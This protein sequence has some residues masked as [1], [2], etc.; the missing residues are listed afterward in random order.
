MDD[1]KRIQLIEPVIGEEEI[2]AVTK[3]LR[4]GWL[5]EGSKTREFEAM[6]AEFIGAKHALATNNCTTALELSLRITGV[7]RGDKVIVPDFTHPATAD[8]VMLV[9]ATPVLVDVDF[10]TYNIDWNQFQKAITNK[11]KCVLP[12]SWGGCPL[13]PKIMDDLRKDHGL[14][15]LEDAACSLGSEFKGIKSG[16]MAD[17]SCFSFHPRKIITTGEGGMITTDNADYAERALS[18]KRFGSKLI[19]GKMKFVSMGTNF[20]LSDVLAAIGVE[21]M[22]K[23]DKILKR[24]ISLAHVYDE[25]LEDVDYLRAP[26]VEKGVKHV[27]QT[28]AV[29]VEKEGARDKIIQRLRQKGIET[30]IGTYSLHMQPGFEHLRRIG[31][32]KTSER[33]FRNLLALPMCH[34]MTREE[35]ER[36]VSEIQSVLV[37]LKP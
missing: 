15:I 12:V 5:T 1:N 31:K 23:I 10:Y 22:K 8:V 35:Q 26:H 3:V 27:Y 16:T 2:N 17:M 14:L 25:L 11:T 29:Y 21:Q 19:E 32:L 33:L 28:Y 24:R 18:F 20:K 30:Q 13:N 9:G 6:F 37:S 4:S 7:G 34:N 36:V